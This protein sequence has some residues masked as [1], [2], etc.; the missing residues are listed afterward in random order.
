MPSLTLGSNS[1]TPLEMASA[2]ASFAAG[3]VYRKPRIISKITFAGSDRVVKV[4][5]KGKRVMA[6]GVAAE[7]TRILGMNMRGGTGTR[8]RTSDDRP[9]A[10]KTGTTDNVT[11]RLVLRLHARSRDL[12]LDRLP[13]LGEVSRCT[14]SRVSATVYGGT[15]P[16]A[17][18]HGFMDAALS[19]VS[20]HDFP[21]PKNPPTFISNFRSEFT[22]RAV[23]VVP[24]VTDDK[25]RRRATRAVTAAPPVAAVP[26]SDGNERALSRAG[27]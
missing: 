8:A 26:L 27:S 23:V 5:S 14:T 20:P 24:P 22:E 2:Y 17:I 18:W 15:L 1:V 10:G 16:A 11:R 4:K 19:K 12:R 6:D 21:E 25:T 9:Q 13:G 7:V 3:G